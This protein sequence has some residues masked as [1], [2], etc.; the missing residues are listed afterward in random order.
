MNDEVPANVDRRGESGQVFSGRAFGHVSAGIERGTVA[1][2]EICRC[3]SRLNLAVSMG[4]D[5]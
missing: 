2:A 1:V 5:R 3:I 4:A